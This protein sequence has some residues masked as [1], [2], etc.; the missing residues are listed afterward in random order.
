MAAIF[1][2]RDIRM[3]EGGC[4]PHGS[5]YLGSMAYDGRTGG[6]TLYR[7]GAGAT[8][9]IVD[10]SVTVS[11]GI[12]WSPQETACYYVDS[13]TNRIDQY[14]WAARGLSNRRPLVEVAGDGV[15]DGL[16]VDADGRIWVAVFGGAGSAAMARPETSSR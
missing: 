8:P 4:A 15:P 12:D 9:E 7:L 6:G 13:A 5:L 11:N 16:T 10:A 2:S 14:D 3:N 1:D